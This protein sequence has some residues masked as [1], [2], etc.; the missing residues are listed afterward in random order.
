MPSAMGTMEDIVGWP[1]LHRIV[2]AH[3]V[4]EHID[5]MDLRHELSILF[6]IAT[7]L[8]VRF[9]WLFRKKKLSN[10]FSSMYGN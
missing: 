9:T 4:R 3:P 2:W 5:N 10:Q 6:W 1:L 7:L 8:Y